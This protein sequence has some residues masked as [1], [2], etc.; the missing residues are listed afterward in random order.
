MFASGKFNTAYI[1]AVENVIN[2]VNAF[3][4]LDLSQNIQIDFGDFPLTGVDFRQDGS[5]LSDADSSFSPLDVQAQLNAKGA[6]P[7]T[8]NFVS[9]LSG[10]GLS[11]P[12][13][14]SPATV[15]ALLQGKMVDLFTYEMPLLEIQFI[16]EQSFPILPPFLIATLG[17][18]VGA[19][20]RLG[21]GFDTY[22]IQKFAD[23]DSPDYHDPAVIFDGFYINDHVGP[24]GD[25]PELVLNAAIT[26]SAGIGV[27]CLFSAGVTGGVYANVNFDMSDPNA[28][29]K[30]RGSELVQLLDLGPQYLFGMNGRVYAGLSAYIWAGLDLWFTRI[31]FYRGNFSIVNVTLADFT[32]TPL[33]SWTA[34]AVTT[35]WTAGP[36]MTR[37]TGRPTA[38]RTA[39][40]KPKTAATTRCSSAA[41][42]A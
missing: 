37:T 9:N 28:D 23:P 35:C 1:D 6:A 19:T 25:A 33:P 36:T 17:G 42:G 4:G 29:G 41:D 5:K 3:N 11:F 38:A 31:T 7:G 8:K 39:S 21:F 10:G 20:V 14:T 34:A 12:L 24:G 13:L 30:L 32:Y 15:F 27:A 40:W 18:S 26:G 2:L 22:G 16:Y